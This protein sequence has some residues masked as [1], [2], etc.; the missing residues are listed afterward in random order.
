MSG[1]QIV[2]FCL[3]ALVVMAFGSLFVVHEWIMRRR[4]NRLRQVGQTVSAVVVDYEYRKSAAGDGSTAYPIVQF[5]ASDGRLVTAKT[6]FGGSFVPD[7]GEHMDVLFDPERP[8]EVHND[9]KLSNQV[10]RVIGITG[11]VMIGG[12]ALAALIVLAVF[13]EVWL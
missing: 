2:E 13:H 5:Q 6:D 7:I 10:N 3:G 11:W 4:I 1:G 8:D 9:S 12:A